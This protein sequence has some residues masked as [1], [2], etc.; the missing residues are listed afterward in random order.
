MTNGM[1]Q[2]EGSQQIGSEH[3]NIFL[4]GTRNMSAKSGEIVKE[5]LDPSKVRQYKIL[6]FAKRG[7]KLIYLIAAGNPPSMTMVCPVTDDDVTK[8]NTCSAMSST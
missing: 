4:S 7:D 8:V 1:A 5:S 6:F 3:I 2:D